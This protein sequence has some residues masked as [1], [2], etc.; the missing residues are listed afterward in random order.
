MF[1]L[2]DFKKRLLKEGAW[3]TFGRVLGALGLLV[4]VRLLTEV[5]E[6]EVYGTVSLLVGVMTLGLNLLVTPYILAG[7]RLHSEAALSGDLPRLRQA[8]VGTLRWTIT[9]LAAA[10]LLAGAVCSRLT[11]ISYW[12]FAVLA[13]FL[14]VQAV[15]SLDLYLL[16]AA[17]RQKE[18]SIWQ[19][20]EAWAK[21]ALA[22]V[23]VLVLGATPQSVLLGYGLAVGGVLLGF[24]LLGLPR[25]GVA[26]GQGPMA[27]NAKLRADIRRYATP[28]IPLALVGWVNTLS[29]RYMIGGLL[30]LG[31]VGVYSATYG[32]IGMP[33]LIAGGA[34]T[35][36]L[37]PPYFQAVSAGN[38]G[39]E[40]NL[41][42]AW[43]LTTVLVCAGGA[44][45]VYFL[46]HIIAA[47]LLAA[48]YRG[49]AA[50][51]SWIAAGIG[52]QAV[53]QV[54]EN[55]LFAYKRT[56]WVLLQHSAGAAVCLLS[57]FVLIRK[58][59]LIGAAAACPVYYLSMVIVGVV[60][61]RMAG[62]RGQTARREA[63]EIAGA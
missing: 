55:V 41:L 50:L 47:I 14:V 23:F 40:R 28:L 6:K 1:G 10:T 30:S 21:P 37:F 12:A 39:R 35:Q 46:R 22:I 9:A 15:R 61:A 25:E 33:F 59:G 49:G 18:N 8:I 13:A 53:A 52:L 27:P 45:A 54:F 32:L 34:I 29:D 5:V 16:I 58:F 3:S 42:N 20:A 48:E 43:L 19:A 11:E 44:A 36:A 60:L 24:L 4:G 7:Q 38:T 62:G 17:R 63:G 26:D 31:D 51:M 57:V 56:S 2:S